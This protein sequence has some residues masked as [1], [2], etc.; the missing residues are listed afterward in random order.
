MDR[1]LILKLN[2]LSRQPGASIRYI[3][4]APG[5]SCLTMA[6]RSC[7]I[8]ALVENMSGA[9]RAITGRAYR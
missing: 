7:E 9:T 4:H 3:M 2:R 8:K 6:V 1:T 5:K